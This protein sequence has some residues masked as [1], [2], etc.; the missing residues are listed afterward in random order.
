MTVISVRSLAKYGIVTDVDPYELP[1]EAWSFGVNVRFRNGTVSRAPV[2]RNVVTLSLADPRFVFS[3]NPASG[4]DYIFI[5]Y[6]L[7]YIKRWASGAETDYSIAGF[8]PAAAEVAHTSTTLGSVIYSNRA[9]RVPWSFGPADTQFHALA[10]WTSTWSCQLLRTCGGALVALN[11]TKS[12]V[13]T[14]TMVK[15]SSIQLSG[16]VPASWDQTLPATL[17]TENILAD[18]AGQITDAAPFGSSLVIYGLNEAWLMVADGSAQVYNYRKLPFKKGSINVN[19][20]LQIDGKHLVFGPNDIWTHDGYSEQSLCNG[21]VRDFIYQGLNLSKSSRCFVTHNEKLKEVHFCYV[22]ADRGVLTFTD[23]TQGCNRQAVYN[24][25]NSP[26]TW[27]FDDL[28]MVYA[29]DSANL[30]T[31]LTWATVTETW[32][33]VGSTWS[34]QEDG[35]KRTLCYVGST[36]A[37]NSLTQSLY[38]FD[39]YGPGSTVVYS[40]DLNATLPVQLEKDGIDLD[41][42]G[43]D[44]AGYKTVTSLTP[45][46]RMVP[47]SQPMVFTMGSSDFFGGPTTYDVATQTYDSQSNYKLD[48]RTSGRALGLKIAYNDIQPFSLTGIDYNIENS[49]ER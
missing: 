23:Q 26:P 36:W 46:G 37:P 20:T 8:T 38:A 7:G 17:A 34:D 24:Y 28:P 1:K 13:N 6:K 3:A 48:Y 5:N 9:D 44:L 22:A 15:T 43:I 14:P 27:T 47:G 35:F 49:G 2:F 25:G 18:M 41:G 29:A 11:V 33:S 32:A 39:L 45:Q 42:L 10:N 12:G 19:C 16:T 21:V 31:T 4:L 40:V 30:D